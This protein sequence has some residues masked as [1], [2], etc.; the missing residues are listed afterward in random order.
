MHSLTAC[1]NGIP[2]ASWAKQDGGVLITGIASDSVF[3][4]ALDKSGTV[5]WGRRYSTTLRATGRGIAEL[6]NGTIIVA[7]TI[8]TDTTV[9]GKADSWILQLDNKGTLLR[10][11]T[12]DV[13][14]GYSDGATFVAPCGDSCGYMVGGNASDRYNNG[15]YWYAYC[16]AHSDT[17]AIVISGYRMGLRNGAFLGNGSFCFCGYYSNDMYLIKVRGY[18]YDCNTVAVKGI[19]QGTAAPLRVSTT[20]NTKSNYFTADGRVVPWPVDSRSLSKSGAATGWRGYYRKGEAAIPGL[21]K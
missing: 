19:R 7:A 3:V 18:C 20:S 14:G 8:L 12:K 4:Y 2:F 17:L 9:G 1:R 13:S 21:K 15:E 10:S 6:K 11:W 5:E 16:N